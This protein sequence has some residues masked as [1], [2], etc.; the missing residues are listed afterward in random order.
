[1][2]LKS[3]NT[4]K[5][6]EYHWRGQ[7]GKGE[8]MK[9]SLLAYGMDEAKRVLVEQ[10]IHILKIK[11]RTPSSWTARRHRATPE[12][13]NIFT[14][15][16]ATML[17]AGI[18]FNEILMLLKNSAKK[19][20]M[21]QIFTSILTQVEAGTPLSQAMQNS[22]PLIDSFYC[23]LASTGE[24]TGD[25]QGVFKRISAYQQKSAE[26]RAK[27]KKAMIYPVVIFI[28][29]LLV[30][31]GM[32]LFVIPTFKDIFSTF[33]A[34]LPWLTQ[35]LLDLSAFV[36]TNGF[37]MLLTT[38]AASAAAYFV[39]KKN[40]KVRLQLSKYSLRIPIFGELLLK[41]SVA[42]F[43]RTLA[44]T[45]SAGIPLL[46]GMVTAQRTTQNIYFQS[47][48]KEAQI[49]TASGRPLHLAIRE[50]QQFPDMALQMIMVGEESGSLDDMLNKIANVYEAE[51]T[52]TIDNLEKILEPLIIVFLGLLIGS[53]VVAMY[54]PMFN[55]INIMS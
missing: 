22:S 42:N 21:K 40:E 37:L 9:G 32:L 26:I 7:T 6:Y 3:K 53:L 12:D 1:M 23:A 52:N 50:T 54:L 44:A 25:L 55:L 24:Q 33:N 16:I 10:K 38:I 19:A 43:S 5:L 17:E 34:D 41:G 2:S 46:E 27:I 8:K 28:S 14:Q 20:Q 49:Q 51:I 36:Q 48:I 45:F 31:I 11:Q 47:L 30:S 13:I 35:K 18:S 29:A 39:Y 15:Q 4:A